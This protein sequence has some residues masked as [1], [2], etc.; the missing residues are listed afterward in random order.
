MSGTNIY[1]EQSTPNKHL[2]L[3]SMISLNQTTDWVILFFS[4]F[5]REKRRKTDTLISRTHLIRSKCKNIVSFYILSIYTDNIRPTSA[6]EKWQRHK[7][8]FSTLQH[9]RLGNLFYLWRSS[10]WVYYHC[11]AERLGNNKIK[12]KL[13]TVLYTT[14]EILN[15]VL[16]WSNFEIQ[17][18]SLNSFFYYII[19]NLIFCLVHLVDSI[20]SHYFILWKYSEY[21]TGKARHQEIENQ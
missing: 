17:E 15:K 9:F 16:Y 3:Y 18:I 19:L 1:S 10:S 20:Y 4:I 12:R 5:E 21:L 6:L 2:N 7:V 13:M 11:L 14:L 8:W